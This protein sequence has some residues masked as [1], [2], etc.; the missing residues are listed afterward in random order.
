MMQKFP[1]LKSNQVTLLRA[2]IATGHVVDE[3]FKLANNDDQ[4]VYTVFESEKE[5]LNTAKKIVTEKKNIEC[6]I[7]NAN[8]KILYQLDHRT[9]LMSH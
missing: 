4:T 1:D 5:A 3:N 9:W 2:E 7:Y 8:E 6:I